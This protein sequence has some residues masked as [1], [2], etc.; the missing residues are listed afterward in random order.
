MV[1]RAWQMRGPLR[2]A[3][4][5]GALAGIPVAAGVLVDLELDL[6]A[7]GAVATG[8]LLAGFVAFDAPAPTRAVWLA[9]SAP[10]VGRSGARPV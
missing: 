2:P 1:P 8:A 5:R 3:L 6:A 7:A 9:L 10:V 4:G